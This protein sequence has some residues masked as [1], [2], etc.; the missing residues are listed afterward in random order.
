MELDNGSCKSVVVAEWMDKMAMHVISWNGVV[1]GCRV[2]QPTLDLRWTGE[3]GSS[4][5]R[6]MEVGTISYYKN[7]GVRN[8]YTFVAWK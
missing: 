6:C 3:T 8:C 4:Y 2:W 5:L 7:K 1:E